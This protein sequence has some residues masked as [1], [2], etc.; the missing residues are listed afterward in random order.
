MAHEVRNPLAG[1]SGA[2][3][4]LR[5]ELPADSPRR[6]VIREALL[7]IRRLDERVRDLLIYARPNIPRPSRI[8]PGDMI[9]STLSLLSGEP[10]LRDVRVHMDVPEGLDD[11]LLDP[12]QIQEVL[13]NL[14]RNAAD[15]MK[16][17]GDLYLE[18]RRSGDRLLLI[19]EDTGP[20]VPAGRLN[21]IFTPFMTTRPDGTGLGLS[22]SRRNVE[23]HGGTLVCET[24]RQ[25][26]ARFVATLPAPTIPLELEEPWQNVS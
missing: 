26:G 21:D 18:A 12:T 14:I 11:C 7:L 24:G 23:A 13:V 3:E 15:A 22:I 5:D 25:G 20:G 10:M 8:S 2:L 1:I 6:E 4:I 9:A 17:S 19:V 16:G